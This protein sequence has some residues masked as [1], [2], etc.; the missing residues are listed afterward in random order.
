MRPPA[1]SKLIPIAKTARKKIEKLAYIEGG[2]SD[3]AGYCGIAARYIELVANKNNIEVEFVAGQFNSYVR[4]ID[5]YRQH[6]GHCWLE[7]DGYIVDITATQ[8]KDVVSKV[9][10]NF[11]KKIYTSV[12]NNPHYKKDLVGDAAKKCVAM[13]YEEAIDYVVSKADRI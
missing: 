12:I 7:C 6:S 11:G 1:L 3:L 10:R 13:W 8:F 2:H 9:K 5:V 4:T